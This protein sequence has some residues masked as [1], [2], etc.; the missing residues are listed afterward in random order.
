[1][2]QDFRVAYIVSRF[3]TVTETFIL[4]EILELKRLGVHIEIFPLL[5]QNESVEHDEVKDLCGNVHYLNFFSLSV[6]LAQFYWMAKR[7]IKYIRIWW[8]VLK[9]NI[10]SLKFLSRAIVTLP[11]AASF[12]IQMKKLGIM[13]IHAHWATHPALAAYVVRNLADISFSFTAHAHDI[14]VERSMLDKKIKNASFLVTISEYNLRML[15][16]LYGAAAASKT[17]VIR[18]GVNLDTFQLHSRKRSKKFS[19][20]CVASLKDYKGH[21]FLLRAC[22]QLKDKGVKFR[23]LLVGDGELRGEIER[24]IIQLGLSDDVKLLGFRPHHRVR[25]LLNAADVMVLPSVITANGKKEGIPVALMEALASAMP[26]IST[27]ISGI[28]ELIENGKTGLLIPERDSNALFEAL[29]M[30]YKSPEF[31]EELGKAGRLRVIQE[32][33]LRKNVEKLFLI[34]RNTQIDVSE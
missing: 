4:Y 32:Y 3:P 26:V 33:D 28:P 9:G 34:L 17:H 19:I 6:F 18:C 23:C 5:R 8:E 21:I 2:S 25:Q 11:L 24:N 1:M 20:I 16:N 22:S 13:H 14:Y 15:E 29:L 12:A 31:A 7:P 27:A 10:K 30:I